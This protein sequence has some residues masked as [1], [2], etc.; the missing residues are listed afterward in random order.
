MMLLR[1]RKRCI[2][3]AVLSV[4]ICCLLVLKYGLFLSSSGLLYAG[5]SAT[6]QK[7]PRNT[8]LRDIPYCA[9]TDFRD[10]PR[11]FP[12]EYISTNLSQIHT[13]KRLRVPN[14]SDVRAVASA[15]TD[16]MN[17]HSQ[18]LPTVVAITP[19]YSRM[20]QKADL[21]RLCYTLMHVPRVHWIVVE[22]SVEKTATVTEILA[23]CHGPSVT[24]LTATT[25]RKTIHRGIDQRNAAL[26]WI[27]RCLQPSALAGGV[28]FADDDNTYDLLL[29]EA[30]RWTQMVSIWPV[31]MVGRS[32]WE[33]P[34]CENGKVIG[35]EGQYGQ[36]RKFP[37]DMA[38]FSINVNLLL[39]KPKVKFQFSWPV[40]YL[41]TRYLE[42]FQISADQLKPE[43][44]DNCS[45]VLAWHTKTQL[46][47]NFWAPKIK[48]DAAGKNK[49]AVKSDGAGKN[50]TIK[51]AG[52]NNINIA[53][54]VSGGVNV[55]GKNTT[56]T[57]PSK[58]IS[59]DTKVQVQRGKGN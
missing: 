53:N 59:G 35:W 48:V 26:D 7:L 27:R 29:F 3:L 18:E 20:T 39:S 22:D 24:H 49:A 46:P 47:R 37:V 2:S 51:I 8:R 42:S 1:R 56:K 21:L 45:Q 14:K 10:P 12:M 32:L 17:R 25:S 16:Y 33:G 11:L 50:K 5:P 58:N 57:I 41:E 54:K 40:G 28:Y 34:I 44:D 19:T 55:A 13:P 43:P 4:M 31:G 9:A 38:S 23:N 36:K 30:V 15:R 6:S 52:K